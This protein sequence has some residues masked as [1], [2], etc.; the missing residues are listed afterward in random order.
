MPLTLYKASLTQGKDMKS[1]A[2]LKWQPQDIANREETMLG[3]SIVWRK[4]SDEKGRGVFAM[5][6]LRKGEII[7]VAPVIP[8]AKGNIVENGNA[9]DGYLLQWDEDTEGEEYAMPLGY[10]MM[11]NHS[12][13]PTIHIESNLEDYTMTLTTLRDIK[14]GEE[15]T[16]NYACELWFDQE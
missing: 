12:E 5:R 2:A 7:E 1:N 4:I 13:A 15:L 6:D 11:Y 9:P 14:A 3:A 16:W 8:V 10:V